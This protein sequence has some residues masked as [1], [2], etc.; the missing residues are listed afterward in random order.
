MK[1]NPESIG[2][3][4]RRLR[5]S[6]HLTQEQAADAAALRQ[7]DWSKLER[8]ACARVGVGRLGR[9]AAVL[10]VTIDELVNRR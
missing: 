9:I 2:Q 3:R 1:A 7:S 6:L 4:I 5:E 8:S 10:D